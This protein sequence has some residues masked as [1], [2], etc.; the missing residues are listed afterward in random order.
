MKR[1]LAVALIAIGLTIGGL[2]A[3]SARNVDDPDGPQYWGCVASVTA[4]VGVCLSNPLPPEIPPTDTPA[5]LPKL[6]KAPKL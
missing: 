1:A 3:A 5:D 2:G 6:P 4:D